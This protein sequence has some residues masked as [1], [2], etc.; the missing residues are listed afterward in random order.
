MKAFVKP[1]TNKKNSFLEV[2]GFFPY[3]CNGTD[4][5]RERDRSLLLLSTMNIE[6]QIEA[7]RQKTVSL[8]ENEAGVFLVDIRIK[9]T[10]NV[11]IFVDADNGVSIDKLVQYN[12]KLYKELEE[13][14]FFP[15]NDFSL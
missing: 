6:D 11:K 9:P 14:H 10:N 5:R 8:I 13:S 7:L 2:I 12:R 4:I 1:T 3:F 15:G